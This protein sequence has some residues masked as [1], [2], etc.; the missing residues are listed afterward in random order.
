MHTHILTQTCRSWRRSRGETGENVRPDEVI[1]TWRYV[2]FTYF[3]AGFIQLTC[4]FAPFTCQFF[5][6]SLSLLRTHTALV[7]IEDV[8]Y[9]VS[10]KFLFH[11]KASMTKW[12]WTP[13]S[14]LFLSFILFSSPQSCSLCF[15]FDLD[16]ISQQNERQKSD[17]L[18]FF[19]VFLSLLF[20]LFIC[21]SF[22]LYTVTLSALSQ[23]TKLV[24]QDGMGW[25]RSCFTLY[26]M[27][28][29]NKVL[30]TYLLTLKLSKTTVRSTSAIKLTSFNFLSCHV[31]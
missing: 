15:W 6:F 10:W 21:S 26:E 5:P 14:S 22:E 12:K 3:Q 29:I 17:P 2:G 27:C 18:S 23:E 28:Y 20:N 4:A 8:E 30:L 19:L 16:S 7:S 25:D 24:F 11:P 13:Y 1:S 31:V 9:S